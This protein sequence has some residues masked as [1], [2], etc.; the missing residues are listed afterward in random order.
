MPK[1]TAFAGT[2]RDWEGLIG[3]CLKNLVLL[4]GLGGLRTT[5]ERI[6]D[7]AREI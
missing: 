5:L 2:F 6:L 7:E 3:A 1:I 4:P